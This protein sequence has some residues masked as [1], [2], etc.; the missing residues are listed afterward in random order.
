[1]LNKL[2]D[3]ILLGGY[4]KELTLSETYEKFKKYELTNDQLIREEI[5]VGN[6]YRVNKFAQK[7][8]QQYNFDI[9]D[10]IAQ[11]YE[12]LVDTVDHYYNTNMKSVFTTILSVRLQRKLEDYIM[13]NLYGKDT[14]AN[15]KEYY[16]VKRIVEE[17]NNANLE[18]KPEL[19]NEIADYLCK[20]NNNDKK[21]YYIEQIKKLES[22][23]NNASL[24]DYDI[25]YSDELLISNILKEEKSKIVLDT[26]DKLTERE[27]QIIKLR[28]GFINDDIKTIKEI[29]DYYNIEEDK[30]RSII[31]KS[32]KKLKEYLDPNEFDIYIENEKSKNTSKIINIKY[33][34][35][36][37]R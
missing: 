34:I 16:E 6:M 31:K 30:V 33:Y 32:V 9:E 1:M 12:I 25:S 17:D 14:I 11:G 24:D 8:A 10:L 15:K 26:I 4:M 29:A 21:E 23:K 5:I 28:Y 35:N 3:I 22:F 18:D 13:Y 27:K 2:N 37:R 36:K 19:V 20:I 7:L